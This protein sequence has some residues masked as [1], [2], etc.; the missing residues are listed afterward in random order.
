VDIKVSAELFELLDGSL[1]VADADDL[2][3]LLQ[4]DGHGVG[5]GVGVSDS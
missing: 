4:G 3:L 1:G 5:V 2:L